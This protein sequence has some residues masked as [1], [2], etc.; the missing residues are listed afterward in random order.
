MAELLSDAAEAESLPE[1]AERL[2]PQVQPA[3]FAQQGPQMTSVPRA[4]RAATQRPEARVAL[5]PPT[6]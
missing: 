6:P 3:P 5:P 1:L 4:P 2:L